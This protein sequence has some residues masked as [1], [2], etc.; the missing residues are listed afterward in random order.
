[1]SPRRTCRSTSTISARDGDG[2][3]THTAS[4]AAGNAVDNVKTEGRKFGTVTGMAPA[5]RLAVYKVCWEAADPDNSG[6]NNADIVEAIDQA[7]TDGVDVINFSIGGGATRPSTPPSS[8]S[9]APPRRASSSR[10]RPATPARA[11]P[12]STTRA[13]G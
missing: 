6:C 13:R 8:P 10:R 5:A 11:P 2:H 9:R 4:T 3:G 1:M 12:R 7:V